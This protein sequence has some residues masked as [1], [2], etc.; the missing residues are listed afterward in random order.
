MYSVIYSGGNTVVYTKPFFEKDLQ[1]P[2]ERKS[3]PP[4]QAS[5]DDNS[6]STA[7]CVDCKTARCTAAG[8]STAYSVVMNTSA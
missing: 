8:A 1:N 6:D 5:A 2:R 3:I 7:M 4:D